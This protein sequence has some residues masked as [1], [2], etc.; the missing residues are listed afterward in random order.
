MEW[1]RIGEYVNL[2]S[3][4]RCRRRI[5]SLCEVIVAV[6]G[7]FFSWYR[8]GIGK[9]AFCVL[10]RRMERFGGGWAR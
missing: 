2:F 10:L 1:N 5:H 4:F 9:N 6:T 7:A 8:G 3:Q